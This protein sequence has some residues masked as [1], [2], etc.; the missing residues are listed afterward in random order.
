MLILKAVSLD[1]LHGDGLLLGIQQISGGQ[2]E[3]QGPRGA[4]DAKIIRHLLSPALGA[5]SQRRS[6]GKIL[7]VPTGSI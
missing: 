6:A 5:G 2:L 3:I 1:P 7:T 4:F